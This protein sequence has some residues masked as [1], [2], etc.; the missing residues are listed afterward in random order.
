MTDQHSIYIT[1]QH[2]VNGLTEDDVNTTLIV[3]FVGETDLEYVVSIAR[4]IETA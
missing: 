2:L 3:V 4:Q 1:M